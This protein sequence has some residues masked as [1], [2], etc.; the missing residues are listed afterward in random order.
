MEAT[1]VRPNLSAPH[2]SIGVAHASG[3]QALAANV[4]AERRAYSAF[5]KIFRAAERQAREGG[6]T[7]WPARRG[8]ERA[9]HWCRMRDSRGANCSAIWDGSSP[10]GF[11]AELAKGATTLR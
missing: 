4:A 2:S 11:A 3:S 10:E 5:S 1:S 7:S 8:M 9:L 6:S